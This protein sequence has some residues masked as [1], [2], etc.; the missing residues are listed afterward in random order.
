[1]PQQAFV[2]VRCTRTRRPMI[3]RF[4]DQE[5]QWNLLELSVIDQQ[6]GDR[7]PSSQLRLTG[8]LWRIR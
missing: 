6:F 2:P 8:T 4:V 3:G 1:M 5:G 7:S